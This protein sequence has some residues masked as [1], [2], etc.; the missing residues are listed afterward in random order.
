VFATRTRWPRRP[1]SCSRTLDLHTLRS[2]IPGRIKT[3]YKN[4]GEAVKNSDPLLQVFNPHRLRIEGLV[5]MQYARLLLERMEIVVELSPPPSRR[6][7]C[8]PERDAGNAEDRFN[9][10]ADASFLIAICCCRSIP[11]S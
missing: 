1:R 3:I 4:K 6:R 10:T 2:K 5:E 7:A 11:F 8:A 9:T